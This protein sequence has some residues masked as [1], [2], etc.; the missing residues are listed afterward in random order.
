M[1]A[2]TGNTVA[3]SYSGL[4]KTTGNTVLGIDTTTA[5]SDGAGNETPLNLAQNKVILEKDNQR[6]EVN[7]VQTNIKGDTVLIIDETA[8][9]LLQ[10]TSTSA[11]I[12]NNINNLAIDTTN[13]AFAGNVDFSAATV[14]GLP[15]SGGGAAPMLN[16]TSALTG[17]TDMSFYVDAWRP[18]VPIAFNAFPNGNLAFYSFGSVNAPLVYSTSAFNAGTVINEIEFYVK[19]ASATFDGFTIAIH[20]S[21]IDA[22]GEINCGPMLTALTSNATLIQ[23]TGWKSVTGINYTVPATTSGENVYFIGVWANNSSADATQITLSAGQPSDLYSTY[24]SHYSSQTSFAMYASYQTSIGYSS[25]PTTGNVNI[26]MPGN[27]SIPVI[28]FK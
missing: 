6:I 2:L 12:G 15:S 8:T 23:S 1:S 11:G 22:N 27:N 26:K 3:S 14:T 18:L 4:L 21:Y 20:D 24:L 13:A 17:G 19:T 28:G 9:N 10:V 5:I 7:S 16:P 25:Y